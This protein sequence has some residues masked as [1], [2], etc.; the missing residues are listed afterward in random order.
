[1][2]LYPNDFFPFSGG[3]RFPELDDSEGEYLFAHAF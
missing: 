1:M 2:K 3:I